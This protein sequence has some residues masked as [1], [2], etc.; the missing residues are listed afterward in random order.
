MAMKASSSGPFSG[1]LGSGKWQVQRITPILSGM[2]EGQSCSQMTVAD[3]SAKIPQQY[4]FRRVLP[5]TKNRMVAD[6][7]FK[8][9]KGKHGQKL[10]AEKARV[11]T[12]KTPTLSAEQMRQLFDSFDP[13]K[14]NDL[15][16]RAL[17][18]VMS[19][20]LAR[21]SAALDLRASDLMDLGRTQVLRLQEKG[22][23]Q[24]DIPAH[25]KL[26]EYLDEWIDHAQL[27]GS[28]FLFPALPRNGGVDSSK[29]MTRGDALRMVKR[30]LLKAGIPPVF[31]NHSFRA[32]GITEFLT[33]GGDLETA[34]QLANHADSRTTKLYDR[35]ASRLELEEIVRIRF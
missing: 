1:S 27:R 3:F 21:V 18:A 20:S 23:V 30:R 25:P 19:Y 28:D 17:I 7:L 4:S 35:R 34:Q 26:V 13:S 10:S 12:G 29:S 14:P 11:K 15:R 22:G 33:N 8:I 2:A 31:S 24:R 6:K 32:T 5:S 16:D 9:E